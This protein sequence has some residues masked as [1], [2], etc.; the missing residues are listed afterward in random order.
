[1]QTLNVSLPIAQLLVQR[2]Y[3]DFE[4]AKNFF[5][6]HLGLLHEPLLMAD[7]EKAKERLIKAL[8]KQE[9]ILIYG[10]YD[11]DGTTAVAL[12]YGFLSKYFQNLDYYISDRYQEGYGISERGIQYAEKNGFTLIIS[13]DCGIKS[14][15]KIKIAK[16]KGIDFIVCD[17]HTPGET[18]PEAFAVLNPKR[19]DCPY[20]FKELTGCGVGFK[21]LQA[22]IPELHIDLGQ[23]FTKLDLVAVS[24]A[25]DLVPITGENRIFAKAG[26]DILNKNP[27][28]AL[29]ALCKMA[30]LPLGNL[31]ISD[32]V[33]GIGP[34]INAAGRISHANQAV[35]LLLSKKDETAWEAAKHID[36]KN[37]IRKG[38]DADITEEALRMIEQEGY[39][40]MKTTVLYKANWHKGV[41]GIVASRCVE[42]FYRPTIILTES[43]GKASGSARSVDGYDV[44]Q[45]ISA[46]AELLEHF[47]GHK[48]AAGITLPIEN[49]EKFRHKFEQVVAQSITEEQLTPKIEIDLLLNFDNINEKMYQ[50]LEQFAPFGPENMQ[51]VFAS[52]QVMSVGEVKILKEKHLKMTLKQIGSTQQIEAIGFNMIDFY[53]IVIGKK[54][55]K[56]C[57]TIEM[58]EFRGQKTLQLVLKDIRE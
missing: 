58:N 32:I 5:R 3:A 17:H 39:Q 10:D 57:Y 8:K 28:P 44:H 15:D 30:S 40:D 26:L 46:C 31:K 52:E 13:L 16:Q 54:P 27:Q 43:N 50:V 33:F 2:G 51:P 37:T 36:T 18:L 56:I 23:L 41:V 12:F 55:F 25:C 11:V 4:D 9:K 14:H 22:I 53:P 47:G 42:Y 45:A 24:I 20:P 19:A 35:E 49:I 1:M 7:M 34:R 38:Y 48:Y 6:P 29:K 21:L